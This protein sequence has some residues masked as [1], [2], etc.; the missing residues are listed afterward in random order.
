MKVLVELIR[1]SGASILNR[2]WEGLSL[3]SL[4]ELLVGGRRASTLRAR[5]RSWKR[6]QEFLLLAVGTRHPCH[7]L[8]ELDYLRTRAPEPAP[9]RCSATSGRSSGSL[10]T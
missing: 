10:T 5:A 3:D 2:D 9:S 4:V 6:F 1:A 8:D 7:A